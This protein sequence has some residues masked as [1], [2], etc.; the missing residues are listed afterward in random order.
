MTLKI[1]SILIKQSS[2]TTYNKL[3]IA[4]RHKDSHKVSLLYV[5]RNKSRQIASSKMLKYTNILLIK[6]DIIS[7]LIGLIK[8]LFPY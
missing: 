1:K 4:L 3:F 2:I 5:S 6:S 7:V 8:Y